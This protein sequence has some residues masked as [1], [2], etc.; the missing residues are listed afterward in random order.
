MVIDRVRLGAGSYGSRG[1]I[2]MQSPSLRSD[3]RS[4]RNLVDRVVPRLGAFIDNLEDAPAYYGTLG[5]VERES[6]HRA[7]PAEPE[8]I[9]ILMDRLLRAARYGIE[10]AGPNTY[11]AV[12]NGGL[13]EA[14]IGELIALVLNRY[15]A[16]SFAGPG[17]AAIENGLLQWMASLFGLPSSANG[18]ITTGGSQAILAMM[19]AA[20]DRHLVRGSYS[21]ARLYVSDQAHYCVAKAARIAGLP[22]SAVRVLPTKDGLHLDPQTVAAAIQEDRAAGACPFLLVANAGTTNAGT[23]DPLR[24]LAEVARSH[25]LWYH[26]DACYGGFFILT[27]RGR[28]RLAGVDLADSISLDPHKSLFMPFGTGVLLVREPEDLRAAHSVPHGDVLDDFA[29]SVLPDYADLGAELSREARGPR[30]WLPLHLLGLDAFRNALNEKLELAAYLHSELS[31]IPELQLSEMPELTVVTAWA[32][33][34]PEKTRLLTDRINDAGEAFCSTTMLNGMLVVRFCILS[35][36]T[37]RRHIDRLI[38]AIRRS[39]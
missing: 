14:A 31:L 13:P 10:T 28:E 18:L 2:C 33:A 39:L 27:D 38:R 36:R 17:F 30:L 32:K 24:G 29:S 25:G 5:I 23:I 16:L 11:V 34:G 3:G 37:E 1:G 21:D 15:A 9:D 35:F 26:V 19:I 7:P 20:R 22:A 8:H 6:L 4:F 12:Q